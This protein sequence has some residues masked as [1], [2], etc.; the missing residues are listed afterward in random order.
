MA[1]ATSFFT[2][3]L[4]KKNADHFLK[5]MYLSASLKFVEA[6]NICYFCLLWSFSNS[7]LIVH[8]YMVMDIIYNQSYLTIISRNW[9]YVYG[10]ILNIQSFGNILCMVTPAAIKIVVLDIFW[11]K[12]IFRLYLKNYYIFVINVYIS[13]NFE[14]DYQTK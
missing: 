8:R 6:W 12:H 2:W 1:I 5:T 11:A 4:W 14:Y 3:N 10:Y 13:N 7:Y 9:R